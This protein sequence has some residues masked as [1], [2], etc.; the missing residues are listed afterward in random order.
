MHYYQRVA[1][2][3][4]EQTQTPSCPSMSHSAYGLSPFM[5]DRSLHSPI[6]IWYYLPQSPIANTHTPAD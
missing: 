4:N 1:G 3:E 5:L 6:S 2:L